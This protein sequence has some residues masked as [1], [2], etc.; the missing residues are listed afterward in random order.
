MEN[1]RI[2]MQLNDIFNRSTLRKKV[3]TSG[4]TRIPAISSMDLKTGQVNE[5]LKEAGITRKMPTKFKF[6][7]HDNK[8]MN[9]Y[10]TYQ[11]HR[12]DNLRKSGESRKF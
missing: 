5:L 3:L 6:T 10:I 11:I 7:P 8:E 2:E 4:W 1:Q 9:R 12:L